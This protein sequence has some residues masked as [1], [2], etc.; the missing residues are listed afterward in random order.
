MCARM[1][2]TVV[3]ATLGVGQ[4]SVKLPSIA[5]R[6]AGHLLLESG[7]SQRLPSQRRL[8]AASRQPGAIC[9]YTNPVVVGDGTTCIVPSPAPRSVGSRPPV[10][11]ASLSSHSIA[12][13]S[14]QEKM[15]E[16][17]TTRLGYDALAKTGRT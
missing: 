6:P 2:G 13:M 14:H 17:P 16:A 15:A 1:V 12:R 7:L 4:R 10:R 11:A 8:L 9:A 3:G 5:Y